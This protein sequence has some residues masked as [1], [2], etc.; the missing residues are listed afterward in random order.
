MTWVKAA[1]A[2]AHAAHPARPAAAPLPWSVALPLIL[3]LSGL[4]WLGIFKLIGAL[5]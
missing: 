3:A 1:P 5:L 4:L 2:P